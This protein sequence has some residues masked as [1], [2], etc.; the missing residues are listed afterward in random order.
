DFSDLMVNAAIKNNQTNI[1]AGKLSIVKGQ[2]DQLPFPDN[3]FDIVFCINVAYF[4]DEPGKHLQEIYR[5]VKPG[6]RL[7]TTIRTRG[8]IE[9]MPFTK[10][11]F[12]SYTE[13]DWKLLAHQHNLF[14]KK[15]VLVSEP[16]IE[17]EGNTVRSQ[18]L[19][20]ITEKK[21]V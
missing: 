9:K 11:G 3:S 7:Y 4:W 17:H 19:C 1:A 15:G 16:A 10:Y 21:N 2:S 18:S 14:Y 20:L 6:G 5:V 13:D 12:K 8:S